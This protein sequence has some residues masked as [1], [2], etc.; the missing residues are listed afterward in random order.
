MLTK[1]NRRHTSDFRR[2]GF[3][4]FSFSA[5]QLL[6]AP[7]SMLPAFATGVRSLPAPPVEWLADSNPQFAFRN[8]QCPRSSVLTLTTASVFA[9]LGQSDG[10]DARTQYCAADPLCVTRRSRRRS[11]RVRLVATAGGRTSDVGG[12]RGGDRH[13]PAVLPRRNFSEDGSLAAEAGP[14]S[15]SMQRRKDFG[16]QKPAVVAESNPATAIGVRTFYF[17]GSLLQHHAFRTIH[18]GDVG[19]LIV[20]HDYCDGLRWAVVQRDVSESESENRRK[21]NVIMDRRV[22]VDS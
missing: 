4:H 1:V 10:Q 13:P 14:Q 11:S 5:F 3:Q 12:R 18:A 19:L 7:R 8:S 6:P 2:I 22:A 15:P 9:E 17:K 20:R 16:T 21:L